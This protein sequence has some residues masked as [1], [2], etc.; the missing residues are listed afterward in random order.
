V[1]AGRR[2]VRAAAAALPAVA[3]VVLAKAIVE[4]SGAP[5]RVDVALHAWCVGHRSPA[6]VTFA[7]LVAAT[8]GGVLPFVAAGLAGWLGCCAAPLRKVLVAVAASLAFVAGLLLIRNPLTAA[9][10]RPR[11]P[12]ADWATAVAGGAFPSGHATASAIAAGI[13]VWS[14]RR[15]SSVATARAGVALALSWALAVGMTRVYLGVHWPTDVLGGWVLAAAWVAATTPLLSSLC[16]RAG[17]R[18]RG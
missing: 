12:P 9:I 5:F 11:P 17:R 2:S 16:G 18:S 8:A 7:R 13:M 4:T 10:A 3:F 15:A 14:A 1:S 6:V